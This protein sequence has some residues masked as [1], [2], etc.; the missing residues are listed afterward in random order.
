MS[1]RGAV[2][3]KTASNVR[4]PWMVLVLSIVTLGIYRVSWFRCSTR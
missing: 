3:G 1:Q 2:A 4:W